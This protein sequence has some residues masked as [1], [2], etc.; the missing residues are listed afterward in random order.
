MEWIAYI[1]IVLGIIAG[2]VLLLRWY[3]S[4]ALDKK[5]FTFQNELI[6][7]HVSEV[8]N[9]YKQMR[10]WRHDYHSHIQMLKAHLSLEQYTEI[11]GYLNK[12]DADLTNVD[13]I[14]KTGNVTVDAILNSKISLAL[15][16]KIKVNAK[17]A[18]PKSLNISEVDLCVII[19]NLLD[20]ATEACIKLPATDRVIRI[21]IDVFNDYLYI[22]VANTMGGGIQKTSTGYISTKGVNRGFGL[23]RIDKIAKKYGGHIN[24]QQEEDDFATE[25]MLPL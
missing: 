13:T 6:T 1:G 5:I 8:E 23:M 9:I 14:L 11:G 15:E 16:S 3:I 20:N 7:K 17:A 19:G 21:Y 22:S 18:V 12:L 25:V 10:G 24:R 4:K 2:I